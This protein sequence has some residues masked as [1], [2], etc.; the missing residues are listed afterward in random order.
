MILVSGMSRS[1]R[2]RW[3]RSPRTQV[4]GKRRFVLAAR[5]AVDRQ[6]PEL[7][8]D[9]VKRAQG[10][11]GEQTDVAG[12][13]QL[14]DAWPRH[15]GS[16]ARDCQCAVDVEQQVLKLQ[17]CCA[18][19]GHLNG[20]DWQPT[21]AGNST[22]NGNPATPPDSHPGVPRAIAN[23]PM[24]VAVAMAGRIDGIADAAG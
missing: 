8:G 17:V 1:G 2:F 19:H 20:H 6:V 4:G 9:V 5:D 15:Q 23:D 18:G 22:P 7:L 21:V 10:V 3:P 24:T 12:W 11:G 14:L 13:A 16:A